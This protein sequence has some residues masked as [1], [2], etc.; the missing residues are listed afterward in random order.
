MHIVFWWLADRPAKLELV[1]VYEIANIKLLLSRNIQQTTNNKENN[2][3]NL[4]C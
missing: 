4:T 3:Y 2:N 1:Y